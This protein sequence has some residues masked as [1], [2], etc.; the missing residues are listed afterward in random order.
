MEFY[1]SQDEYESNTTVKS[2]GT[3]IIFDKL[4]RTE[5]RAHKC[6]QT[7]MNIGVH[8]ALH[9]ITNVIQNNTDLWYRGV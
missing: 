7:A 9:G 1:N 5:K 2:Q 8:A 6:P 4:P 3:K